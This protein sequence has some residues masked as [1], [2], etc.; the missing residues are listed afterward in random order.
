V[1]FCVDS[2]GGSALGSDLIWREVV[3]VGRRKPVVVFMEDVA[4]SGGYYVSCGASRIIAQ[5]GTI[6]GSI[7]VVS[8][9]FV[10]GDL[11]ERY[12]VHHEIFT[13]GATATMGSGFARYSDAEWARVRSDMQDVYTRFLRRVAAGRSRPA[14]EIE[15][16]ARGRVWTGLQAQQRGLVDELGDFPLAVQRA[17]ELAGIPA[18]QEVSITTVRAPRAA[19]VPASRGTLAELRTA[20]GDLRALAAEQALLLMEAL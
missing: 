2:V 4:G 5:P 19:P 13:R 14:E 11:F 7:G 20:L 15:A 17:R 8:G 9:K 1:V 18:A 6:T 16:L 3:R 12:G 10:V